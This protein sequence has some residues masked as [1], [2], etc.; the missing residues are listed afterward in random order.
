MLARPTKVFAISKTSTLFVSPKSVGKA[1]NIFKIN[2]NNFHF[3]YSNKTSFSLQYFSNS[4]F[5]NTLKSKNFL[6]FKQLN[7]FSTEQKKE[8]EENKTE[9]DEKNVEGV[10]EVKDEIENKATESK[11]K[12]IDIKQTNQK[13]IEIQNIKQKNADPDEVII[14]AYSSFI[15]RLFIW[16]LLLQIISCL[17]FFLFADENTREYV[18]PIFGPYFGRRVWNK[19]EVIEENKDKI[20][21]EGIE[22]TEEKVEPEEIIIPEESFVEKLA[23][24]HYVLT[25]PV[26]LF[27][28]ML[29][30]MGRSLVRAVVTQCSVS[31]LDYRLT[32]NTRRWYGKTL[33]YRIYPDQVEKTFSMYGFWGFVLKRKDPTSTNPT[34]FFFDEKTL[35]KNNSV[36]HFLKKYVSGYKILKSDLPIV[37]GFH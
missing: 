19:Q 30:V 31:K 5:Q 2:Q 35:A 17:V 27:S 28:T 4:P 10:D 23:K 16:S 8:N 3:Q 32:I 6:S 15:P 13:Q 25:V 20:S 29:V 14:Y 22:V 12:R 21:T 24:N 26:F 36:A 18:E 9:K 11:F 34:F 1:E 37:K 7:R 33:T